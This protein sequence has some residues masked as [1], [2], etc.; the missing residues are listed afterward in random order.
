V[1]GLLLK[2]LDVIVML[3]PTTARADT[4]PAEVVAAVE[5]FSE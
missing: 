3:T 2:M 1:A 5:T 4:T